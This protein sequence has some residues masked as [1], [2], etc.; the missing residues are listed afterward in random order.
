MVSI[1]FWIY[2]SQFTLSVLMEIDIENTVNEMIDLIHERF[3]RFTIR[4]CLFYHKNILRIMTNM[5]RSMRNMKMRCRKNRKRVTISDNSSKKNCWKEHGRILLLYVYRLHNL[6]ARRGWDPFYITVIQPKTG[7]TPLWKE[8]DVRS[9]L[10]WTVGELGS[11]LFALGS[12]KT[13]WSHKRLTKTNSQTHT[14]SQPY[15]VSS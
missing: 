14:Y 7:K 12:T 4:Y 3:D 1:E 11:S 15:A 10:V 2:L 6:A 5:R 9:L 8:E 13:V